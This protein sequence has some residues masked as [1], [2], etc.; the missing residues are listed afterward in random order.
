MIPCFCVKC[1]VSVSNIVPTREE[2]L[3]LESGIALRERG[4]EIVVERNVATGSSG[5]NSSIEG[6]FAAIE[7]SNAS[8]RK[9]LH[10]FKISV[11]EE[12][13]SF[14]NSVG[15][16]LKSLKETLQELEK[17]LRPSAQP[18]TVSICEFLF[19]LMNFLSCLNS[20]NHFFRIGFKC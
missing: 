7:S 13:K 6:R 14:K 20:M 17:R 16:E 1:K 19:A 5:F 15:E 4:E 2:L 3:A 8:V 18:E 9:E 10:E 12:L 11:G